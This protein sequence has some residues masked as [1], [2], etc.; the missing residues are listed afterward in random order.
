VAREEKNG[1]VSAKL[2][3]LQG[4][5]RK[6]GEGPKKREKEKK[7]RLTER[8][9]RPFVKGKKKLRSS[10]L[11][12][13]S[14]AG[15]KRKRTSQKKKKGRSDRKGGKIRLFWDSILQR[16]LLGICRGGPLTTGVSKGR[17]R[18]MAGGGVGG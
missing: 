5:E 14:G 12:N 4:E 11:R 7:K 1:L 10:R 3:K 15:K 8:E 6:W 18:R 9:R 16:K 13:E 17:N 2:G